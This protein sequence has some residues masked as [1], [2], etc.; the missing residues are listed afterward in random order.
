MSAFVTYRG[1]NRRAPER[2]LRLTR[3]SG[4]TYH[5]IEV[6]DEATSREME[7]RLPSVRVHE[8][9]ESAIQDALKRAAR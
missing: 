3:P 8:D 7:G 2:V 4:T 5:V 9:R 1:R 6:E